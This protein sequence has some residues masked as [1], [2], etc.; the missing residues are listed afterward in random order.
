ML[1]MLI[2]KMYQVLISVKIGNLLTTNTEM[3]YLG[4]CTDIPMLS[5]ISYKWFSP[6]MINNKYEAIK[7]EGA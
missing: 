1:Q 4:Y 3:F 5:S 2:N 7:W 6:S